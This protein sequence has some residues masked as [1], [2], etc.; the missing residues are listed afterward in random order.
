MLAISVFCFD[1][2][3]AEVYFDV[4]L[5]LTKNSCVFVLNWFNHGFITVSE[6]ALEFI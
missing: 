6:R 2:S 1:N 5:Y 4:I 3:F